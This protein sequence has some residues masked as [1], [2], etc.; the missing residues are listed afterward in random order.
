[1]YST[2]M[3]ELAHMEQIE[4]DSLR[5]NQNNT[6]RQI[7]SYYGRKHA[8]EKRLQTLQALLKAQNAVVLGNCEVEAPASS[9]SAPQ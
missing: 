3:S 8:P 9:L 6:A 5:S 2:R 7:L 4:E 1:M